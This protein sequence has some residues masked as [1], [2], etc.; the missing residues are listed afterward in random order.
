MKKVT[1]SQNG[2]LSMV[3][4]YGSI[5]AELEKLGFC[6]YFKLADR[7]SERNLSVRKL[8]ALSGLRL[9]TISDMMLGKK[10][11]INMHHIALLMAALRIHDMS[12]IVEIYIPDTIKKAMDQEKEDWL[13]SLEVP[14]ESKR[15]SA[16]INE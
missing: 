10:N 1:I 16:I 5:D 3:D 14:A 8:A 9:A 12:E 13:H 2:H 11:S 4:S 7:M 6:Y 15:L